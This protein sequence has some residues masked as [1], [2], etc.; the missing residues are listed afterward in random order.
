MPVVIGYGAVQPVLPAALVDPAAWVWRVINIL[1]ALGWYSLAP[2]LLYAFLTV[3]YPSF[4]DR[5]W[6]RLWLCLACFSWV[7]IAAANAGGDQW[8]NPRYRTLFLP[9]MTLLAVWVWYWARQHQDA[10]RYRFLVVSGIF[11]FLFLQ[12]YLSRY[13][14]LLL[15][16]DIRIMI[17]L[18]ISVI[19]LYLVACLARD[20]WQR[21]RAYER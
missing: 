2:V 21:K 5:R 15:H 8:D 1:R 16:L 3:F 19:I 9:W 10:W 14:P 4:Q 6:Q 11:S 18:T 17:M 20:L 13:I 12:W 7:L